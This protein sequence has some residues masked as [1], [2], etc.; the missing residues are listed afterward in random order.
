MFNVKSSEKLEFHTK[1]LNPDLYDLEANT[2]KGIVYQNFRLIPF[3]H[4]D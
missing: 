1:M 4:S 3:M 2:C